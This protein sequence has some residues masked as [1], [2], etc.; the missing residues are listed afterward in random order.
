[1]CDPIFISMFQQF[2][3][4]NMNISL[5]MP[6]TKNLFCLLEPS[7]KR[8]IFMHGLDSPAIKI[9]VMNNVGRLL[10]GTHYPTTGDTVQY[11][12]V[13]CNQLVQGL[14]ILQRN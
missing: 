9:M 8:N 12:D 7:V 2:L 1:M 4:T 10:I 14:S 3:H 11:Q 5:D 13:F 6:R